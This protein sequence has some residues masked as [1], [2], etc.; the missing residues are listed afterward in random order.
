MP[1]FFWIFDYRGVP[2]S[3]WFL[4][5]SSFEKNLLTS[6][7]IL[8]GFIKRISKD[9]ETLTF[10]FELKKNI[11]NL[12]IIKVNKQISCKMVEITFFKR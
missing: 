8:L 11:K 5:Q 4:D 6:A 7:S 2:R 1:P 9:W 12:I 10:S 3:K